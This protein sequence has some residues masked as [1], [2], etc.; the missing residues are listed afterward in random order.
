MAF[1]VGIGGL[2]S[3]GNRP[4]VF[5]LIQET[6]TPEIDHGFFTVALNA[7]LWSLCRTLHSDPY[8]EYETMQRIPL[9]NDVKV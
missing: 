7:R 9:F 8:V 4:K 2:L 1:I 6:L 5:S 3:I